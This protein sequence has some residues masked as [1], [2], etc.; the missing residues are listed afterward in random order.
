MPQRCPYCGMMTDDLVEHL[1]KSMPGRSLL[2]VSN[3]KWPS[4]P[5]RRSLLQDEEAEGG[6]FGTRPTP[7]KS[8]S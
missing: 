1:K 8:P 4:D 6:R 7:A 2:L 5:P 3:S